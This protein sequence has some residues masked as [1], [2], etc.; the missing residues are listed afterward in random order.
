MNRI[1]IF[2]SFMAAFLSSTYFA[3]TCATLDVKDT[4][5]NDAV[6]I[7]CSYPLTGNDCVSLQATAP[8]MRDTSSYKTESIPFSPYL[9][10]NSGTALGAN[11]DDVYARSIDIPFSFCF[12]GKS[13]NKV[14][15]SSN[16]LATF[17]VSQLGK[18]SYP[19]V[20]QTNPNPLL[21]R[22]SIFGVFQDLV[23]SNSDASEIYYSIIQAGSCRKL[24]INFFEGRLSGCEERSSTQI[25]LTEFTNQIEVFIDKKPLPCETAKFSNALLGIMNA[26]GTQGYSPTDRNT[27]VWSAQQEAWKFSP[28]GAL[29]TPTIEWFDSS[30]VKIGTGSTINVCPTQNNRYTAKAM[31]AACGAT[32]ML[33]DSIDVNYS[34]DFPVARDYTKVFCTP[35]GA[36]ENVNLD[37]YQQFLT[38]QSPS[39]LRFT[40]HET[41]TD[42][43]AGT[44]AISN[45]LILSN[46][47]TIFVRI[48]NPSDAMCF[49]VAQLKFQFISNAL[50]SNSVSVC[51]TNNDG[52]E[53]EFVLSALTPQIFSA[54]V[55]G[56]VTY[57]LSQADATANTNAVTKAKLTNGMQF[58]LSFTTSQCS[59][60][61]G[62]ININ[63][64]P[65]P[66][67]N[68]PLTIN[69]NM[70]DINDNNQEPYKFHQNLSPRITSDPNVSVR[71]YANYEQAFLGS[72]QVINSIKEGEYSVFARVEEPGGCFSIAEVKLTV[73]FREIEVKPETKY[74]CFDGTEDVNVDLN[75]LSA[76]MLISSQTGLKKTYH[77]TEGDA[78]AGNAAISPNQV[79][80][81]DGNSVTQRYFVRFE[82][83]EDC[84]TVRPIT[85]VLVHPIAAK[86]NFTVCDFKN[87]STETFSMSRFSSEIAGSQRATIKYFSSQSQAQN[88]SGELTTYTLTGKTEL[89]ARVE[90]NG[91]VEIY[92]ITVSLVTTPTIDEDV[93]VNRT[94]FCDNNNDNGENYD[95]TQHQREKYSG[96]EAV[97]FT[98]FNGFNATNNTFSGQ[99]PDPKN[100]RAT[101]NNTIYVRVQFTGGGC[102]SVSTLKLQVAFIPAPVITDTTLRICDKQFNFNESFNLADATSQMFDP[103]QNTTSLSNITITYYK[104]EAAANAATAG[105]A[106]SS[107]QKTMQ[108]LVTVYARFESKTTGCY[109]V[110]PIYLRT[111]FPPKAINSTISG[112][113]DADLDGKYEVN[114]LNYTSQYVDLVDPDNKF[115]F[116]STLSDAQNNRNVIVDPANYE[117]FPLPDFIFVKVENIPG[118]NDIAKINL[119]AGTPLPLIQK[120]PFLLEICDTNNDQKEIVNLTQFENQMYPGATFEYYTSMSALAKTPSDISSPVA[121]NIMASS[122]TVLVKVS[123]AGF[124]PVLA[125]INVRLNRTPQFKLPTY[126]F[127]PYNNGSVNIAPAFSGED[128]RTFEWKNPDGQVLS[129]S[130]TLQ[131]VKVAGVYTLTVTSANKCSFTT[132]FEVKNYEVPVITQL[133][134]NGSNYTVIATGSKTILYSMDGQ[135]WQSGNTFFNLPVGQTTF[136]VKFFGEDCIGLPKK[137]VILN[138]PNAFTPNEDG[139]NDIWRV[140]DLDVFDGEKSSIQIFDRQ[141]VLLHQEEGLDVLSWNG[142]WMGRPVPTGT[143]WYVLKL[144]D[145]RVFYGWIFLKNRN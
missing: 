20:E 58:W 16:G 59:Q 29:L 91:C 33:S 61:M 98:Y 96:S 53:N 128:L 131:N 115:S 139:I 83:A 26:D 45:S 126:Y 125:Q 99:I 137:G 18:V 121:F 124:C 97:I 12:F 9:P 134:A 116:F 43:Q 76:S 94:S 46:A 17:D 109:S 57:F 132:T 118:C 34:A 69:I 38:P 52:V 5:G 102:F 44:N 70:C 60:V 6:L 82:E 77:L 14:V 19:N 142:R 84:Y 141:Q 143:Y 41:A 106:I 114:L 127:C 31:Y 122:Q 25:V 75:S 35:A 88:N 48:Q 8:E 2:F 11:Y 22:N 54:G 1:C 89:F 30:N 42:A 140:K 78:N 23:F 65:G 112:I 85:L 107:T 71:Y 95:L 129:T 64:T 49:R 21:P 145:S 4:S 111:Y 28:D 130:R 103:A 51:D 13:F 93:T 39:N 63:F 67:V 47:K 81:Q 55:S 66:A 104:T 101:G 24:V 108:S 86:N 74:I 56:T 105:T 117:V 113:C 27:G 7:D 136:Y 3:Q 138:V 110:K 36:T 79:I 144:P 119:K 73:D 123:R 32:F 68:T 10:F 87:D 92:P 62:P 133:I 72:A 15:I 80:T 135:N 90:V 120:G 37:E 100:Y 40:Y 50:T